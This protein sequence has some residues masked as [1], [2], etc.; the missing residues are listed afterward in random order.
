MHLKDIVQKKN[1]LEH[2]K[3][4]VNNDKNILLIN[5][6][7]LTKTLSFYVENSVLNIQLIEALKNKYNIKNSFIE[8][9]SLVKNN[10]FLK[11]MKSKFIKEKELYIYLTEEQKYGTDSYSRYERN[12]LENIK[13]KETDFITIGNRA[14]QFA[15]QNNLSVIKSFEN[16]S[17]N[18]LAKTLTQMTKILFIDNNY[19]RVH[20]VIN[21]NKNF[22]KPFTILPLENFDIDKILGVKNK[23]RFDETI[24][25]YKIFPNIET[26]IE[27]QINIFLENSINSLIT[28][29]SFYSAKN[30]LVATNQKSKQLDD[31]LLKISKRINRVKQEKQI[32]EIVLLTKKKK[33]VFEEGG[34]DEF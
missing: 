8:N 18:K 25:D 15:K 20:F 7:K 22:K 9:V 14:S 6:M 4:K 31:E 23:N 34:S 5:I 17:V 12:I 13:N 19:S 33:T 21:S 28:E 29:S 24:K 26:F 11:S 3:L 16:S 10:N 32:E 27:N 2:I 30:A 1:N